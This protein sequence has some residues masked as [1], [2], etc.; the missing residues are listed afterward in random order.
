MTTKHDNQNTGN[1]IKSSWYEAAKGVTVVAGAFS[2][3]ILGLFVL[4]YLQ[5]KLLDPMRTERLENLK[6]QLLEQPKNEQLISEIRQLD[7]QLRK[8]EIRRVK[9]SQ[10]GALLLLGGI[11]VFLIG[12]KSAKVLKEKLPSLPPVVTDQQERQIRQAILTRWVTV[13]SLAVL[14]LAVLF[15]IDIPGI[16]FAEAG[17]SYPSDE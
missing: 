6:V 13:A 8:D 7:L 10:R 1:S 14:V 17:A 3:I 15:F 4:N 12:I 2:V 5:I 16:D 9:F 11:V